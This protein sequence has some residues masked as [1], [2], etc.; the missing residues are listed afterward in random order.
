MISNMVKSHFGVNFIEFYSRRFNARAAMKY[1]LRKHVYAASLIQVLVRITP[2]I[3]P[4]Q[5]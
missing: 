5:Q 2:A 3:T 4:L 1:H